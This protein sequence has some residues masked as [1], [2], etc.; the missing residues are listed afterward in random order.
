M[1]AA[2]TAANLFTRDLRCGYGYTYYRPTNSC[3]RNSTW[4]Y[5]GRWVVV[6]II[7]FFLFFTL[8]CCM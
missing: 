2:T 5:W 6:G 7:I 4:N 1:D 8:L 3:R